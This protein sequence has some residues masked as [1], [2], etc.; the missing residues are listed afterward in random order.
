MA[1]FPNSHWEKKTLVGHQTFKRKKKK[2]KQYLRN[3]MLENDGFLSF[4]D[5]SESAYDVK[6]ELSLRGGGYS[7][8]E[9][10]S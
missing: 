7:R 2:G 10:I 6:T 5:L 4:L 3:T 8:P 9:N 1:K